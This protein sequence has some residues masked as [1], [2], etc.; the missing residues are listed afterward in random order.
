MKENICITCK[1]YERCGK[2]KRMMRC[3]AYKENNEDKEI[4]NSVRSSKDK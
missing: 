4:K 2:P 1:Y 3:L